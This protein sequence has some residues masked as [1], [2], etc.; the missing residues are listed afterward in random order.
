MTELLRLS[1]HRN[2]IILLQFSN[3]GLQLATAAKDGSIK[4]SPTLQFSPLLFLACL[5]QRFPIVVCL[6]LLR[7]LA[8]YHTSFLL[9]A[10]CAVSS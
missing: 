3:S 8:A 10:L 5:T 6:G 9:D 4:V 7:A 2:D 1:G